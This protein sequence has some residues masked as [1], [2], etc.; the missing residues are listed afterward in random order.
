MNIVPGKGLE[1]GRL[2]EF[3]TLPST[4]LWA[5]EN[6]RSLAHGDVVQAVK[7]TSG[8]GRFDRN[9]IAP[10]NRSLTLSVILD[11]NPPR[12]VLIS[13]VS[14]V[15]ALAVAAAIEQ[16]GIPAMVK[17]PNDV[18]AGGRKISGILAERDTGTG[19]LVIG[20]GINVN[21]TADD[22]AGAS[23]LQPA[24]SMK[25]ET[26]RDYDTGQVM[27]VFLVELEKAIGPAT[28]KS[29][30]PIQQWDSKDFLKGKMIEIQGA[31]TLVSGRYSGVDESGRLRLTGKSGKT[32]LFWSGDVSVISR[33]L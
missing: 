14:Q 16:F 11:P 4:N 28:A 8:R 18:M 19:L 10:R 25:I 13:T 31:D 3:D 1:N 12:D 20:T 33:G 6:I 32:Q 9:W 27:K 29:D 30:F 2:F 15:T 17:W 26:H 23:L 21:M 7:Q 22:F 5:M 24:T